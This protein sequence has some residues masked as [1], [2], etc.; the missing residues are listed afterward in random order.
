MLGRQSGSPPIPYQTG[1][2]VRT[3]LIGAFS[4]KPGAAAWPRR[5][6][7]RYSV[8]RLE[9]HPNIAV[10]DSP[11]GPF[12]ALDADRGAS[13][14]S[15]FAARPVFLITPERSAVPPL[16]PGEPVIVVGRD[17]HQHSFAKEAVDRLRS[18]HADLLVVDMG[19]PSEDRCYADVAT[20][21]G[22]LLMGRALLRWLAASGDSGDDKSP[23]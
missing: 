4:V 17:I 16:Q 10:G 21:G 1:S 12:A 9:G 11:W 20:F 22:S 7:D 8:V 6:S 2:P 13:A 23:C 14:E 19:W 18:A 3:E 15:A 5:A